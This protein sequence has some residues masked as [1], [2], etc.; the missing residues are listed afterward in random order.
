MT[1]PIVTESAP[2]EIDAASSAEHPGPAPVQ[3]PKPTSGRADLDQRVRLN[4][5]EAGEPYLLVFGHDEGFEAACRG[6]AADIYAKG[7]PR[8]NV[9][10]MLQLADKG[11]AFGP[12]RLPNSDNWTP[13]EQKQLRYQLTQ[14]LRFVGPD[15]IQLGVNPAPPAGRVTVE[16]D[17]A[18][19][20]GLQAALNTLGRRSGDYPPS[21]EERAVIAKIIETAV[22]R[23]SPATGGA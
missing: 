19:V 11:A 10:S 14:R 6:Y 7:G 23:L 8:E 13:A 5:L 20:V 15:S 12:K 9:E 21:R 17:R 18:L 16:E 3:A 2:E 1:D 22:A 4:M